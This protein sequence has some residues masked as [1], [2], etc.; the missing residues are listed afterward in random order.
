MS[1]LKRSQGGRHTADDLVAL[2][3]GCHSDVEAH[4]AQAVAEGVSVQLGKVAL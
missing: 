1:R 2:C 3:N 4:P